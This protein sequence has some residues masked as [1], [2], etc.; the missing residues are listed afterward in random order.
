M[1]NKYLNDN[2]LPFCKGCGHILISEN[3]EKALNNMGIKPLDV[4]LVTDIG[5]HGI[6]DKAFQ[7]HTVHGLHGRS[8]ALASGISAGLNNLEKKVLVFLGDGGATIGIQHII[9]AAHNNYSMTVVIH[10]NF[11]YG[12]TG[13]QP[14][15]FTPLGFKTPTLTEGADH[16]NYDICEIVAA[17][18][19]NYVRRIIGIGDFSGHLTEAF[20]TK[21]FSLIEII[22]MCPSYGVKANPG[23]KLG[24]VAEE[25]GLSSK[26]YS[27][28]DKKAFVTKINNSHESL[29]DQIQVLLVKYKSNI[30]KPVRIMLS[31]SAGEGV[32]VAAELFAKSAI[33]SGLNSII[34][35]SYPVTVGVGFSSS[36]VIISPEPI[37]YTGF[38]SPQ[39]IFITSQDGLD[40]SKATIGKMNEEDCVY[41]DESL[42]LLETKAKIIK[43]DFRNKAGGKF[44]SIYALLFYINSTKVFPKEAFYDIF[45]KN[46]KGSKVDIT[47]LL[48]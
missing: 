23:M 39:V 24:K 4:I 19:A 14:S 6:I 1:G 32:Q 22:E 45:T 3:T 9:D 10:N 21:G 11:L 17:A 31:G 26:L 5:C 42:D 16:S 12:M 46:M 40:Y 30:K 47:S 37:E 18:G 43:H 35:G 15:E 33:I 25:A 36:E 2:P 20:S 48:N 41:L 7:T 28:A 38:P 44:A 8:V 27:K 34:K 13:G 29:I